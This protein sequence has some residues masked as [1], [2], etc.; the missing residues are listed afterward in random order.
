MKSAIA[1]AASLG[2]LWPAVAL[3]DPPDCSR[4]LRQ[5]YHHEDMVERAE[6]VGMDEW[7]ETTREHVERL[8][9]RLA[10]RC[11]RYSARDEQQEIAR[12]LATLAKLAANTVLEI[13]TLGAY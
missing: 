1:L 13:I 3:A 7:A 2:L 11:P 4:L 10:N 6:D 8:E 9:D 5:I 12:N